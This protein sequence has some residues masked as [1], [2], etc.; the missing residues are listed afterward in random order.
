M[1]TRSLVGWRKEAIESATTAIQDSIK[2]ITS[3]PHTL[4]SWSWDG[5]FSSHSSVD[6]WLMIFLSFLATQAL[7]AN[8]VS[9][10]QPSSFILLALNELSKAVRK[11]GPT[12]LEA[13]IKIV[14]TVLAEFQARCLELS[15]D[16]LKAIQ[17]L[18]GRDKKDVAIQSL[19]DLIFLRRFFESGKDQEWK[20][21]ENQL[22]DIVSQFFS[23][24]DN[25]KLI[26]S[27]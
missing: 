2:T 18:D 10:T 24:S 5:M 9:P 16:L 21:V 6:L 11:I 15:E 26:D 4:A 25:C 22:L 1:Q 14:V 23:L 3:S 13:D 8:V 27:R 20:V 17:S 7:D 19:W 12:R